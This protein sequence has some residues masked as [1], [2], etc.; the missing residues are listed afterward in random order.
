[1]MV[2]MDWSKLIEI[3]QDFIVGMLAQ[4]IAYVWYIVGSI[5]LSYLVWHMPK[6]LRKWFPSHDPIS[7]MRQRLPHFRVVHFKDID[8]ASDHEV[9]EYYVGRL[10]LNWKIVK[11]E[12]IIKRTVTAEI[13]ERY[14]HTPTK[15]EIICIHG[16]A[17]SGKSAVA[18]DVAYVMSRKTKSQLLQDMNKEIVGWQEIENV[19]Y[20]YEKPLIVVVDDIFDQ[21]E[22]VN[23]M[24]A[25]PDDIPLRVIATSR[26]SD[27]PQ[28]FNKSFV[29]FAVGAP[30]AREIEEAKRVITRG[31]KRTNLTTMPKSWLALMIM[32]SAN[33][34]LE[35]YIEKTTLK[36]SANTDAYQ[37]FLY[38]CFCS[39]FNIPL[40]ADVLT[41]L[42][43]TLRDPQ[44]SLAGFIFEQEMNQQHAFVTAH[45]SIAD[46]VIEKATQETPFNLLKSILAGV[47][48]S[49]QAQRQ[50]VIALLGAIR[51]RQR[52]QYQAFLRF[53]AAGIDLLLKHVAH[54]E[55]LRLAT[56]FDLK[57]A[58]SASQA[59]YQR[60]CHQ[61]LNKI[62]TTVEDWQAYFVLS[63]R[64]SHEAKF[65]V[66]VEARKFVSSYEDPILRARFLQFISNVPKSLAIESLITES[67]SWVNNQSPVDLVI[68]L[69]S[70]AHKNGNRKQRQLALGVVLE[71]MNARGIHNNVFDLYVQL[72]G[73]LGKSAFADAVLWAKQHVS[74]SESMHVRKCYL[75]LLTLAEDQQAIR[76][77]YELIEKE[78]NQYESEAFEVYLMV[79]MALDDPLISR[80]TIASHLQIIEKEKHLIRK[81]TLIGLMGFCDQVLKDLQD[82][83]EVRR[84]LEHVLKFVSQWLT[85]NRDAQ[86]YG[87]YIDLIISLD[88]KALGAENI[89]ELKTWI[90]AEAHTIEGLK[91]Y[92]SF[93]KLVAWSAN[94]SQI[95]E[96]VPLAIDVLH[97]FPEMLAL[98]LAILE[99]I[100]KY[101]DF[102]RS[103]HDQPTRDAI[104]TYMKQTFAVLEA[105]QL[106]QLQQ[107]NIEYYK[108]LH[109]YLRFCIRY[110]DTPFVHEVV[111]AVLQWLSQKSP[112]REWAHSC[113]SLIRLIRVKGNSTHINEVIPLGKQWLK[114]STF[115]QISKDHLLKAYSP[116]IENCDDPAVKIDFYH[117]NAQWS[118]LLK[119]ACN[120]L[121][122]HPL[123]SQWLE[124]A[125]LAANRMKEADMSL[126]KQL[127]T[128]AH[129]WVFLNPTD[130]VLHLYVKLAGARGDS[131]DCQHV[132]DRMMMLR[133]ARPQV[134]WT[135]ELLA[136]IVQLR[137][138]QSTSLLS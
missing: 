73:D 58:D 130:T 72:V 68:A 18:W 50:F 84:L 76:E 112:R 129:N 11:R 1:M 51:T 31:D 10:N 57:T 63:N 19:F 7:F 39:Q 125:L 118:S 62:P 127:L 108:L 16:D 34:S 134:I 22:Y 79:V 44:R 137:K 15:L 86:V 45:A 6:W 94:Q 105:Q 74:T 40:L 101:Y 8:A 27:I 133:N 96:R 77:L 33:Q 126:V 104:Q 69:A 131:G 49:V 30:D 123:N 103:S 106:D 53:D 92:V 116:L 93:V 25:L 41:A 83:I 3:A 91:Y 90:D 65:D 38:V 75:K 46:I 78:I 52:A 42:T 66:V 113:T 24:M 35:E 136:Q 4:S 128:D 135:S 110:E 26:T 88:D 59:T 102:S 115:T 109:Q 5:G 23:R 81:P 99:V 60:L 85:L 138:K 47:D 97:T 70:L 36:L 13:L 56:L 17:A 117:A 20:E 21:V 121:L 61:L 122:H 120:E 95:E 67:H 29:Q 54:A 80:A 89:N 28:A 98:R 43:P 32:L 111:A 100:S 55:L 82:D 37:A 124:Y 2:D 71:W 64:T 12:A 119:I 114:S 9:R 48:Y 87:T 107:V 132:A 14:T